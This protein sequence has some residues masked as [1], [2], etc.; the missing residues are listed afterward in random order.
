[1]HF[2]YQFYVVAVELATRNTLFVST[3]THTLPTRVRC[4]ISQWQNTT[5]HIQIHTQF[6][7]FCVVHH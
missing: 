7:A 4:I 5:L 1:M 2:T 3:R 6:H